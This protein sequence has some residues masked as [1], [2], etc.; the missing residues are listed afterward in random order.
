MREQGSS[1]LKL[2]IAVQAP[3]LVLPL[4]A[5][6]PSALVADLGL[7][8]VENCFRLAGESDLVLQELSGEGER[9]EGDGG[10][11]LAK[12]LVSPSGVPAVIDHMSVAVSS[13]QL[14]R[15]V[16]ARWRLL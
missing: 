16:P 5:S 11:G 7:L 3:F 13:V 10:K 9:E 4:S 14:G 12:S 2:T 6:S 1:R 8:T 15:Q